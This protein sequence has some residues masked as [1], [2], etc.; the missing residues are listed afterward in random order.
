MFMFL[1]SKLGKTCLLLTCICSQLPMYAHVSFETIGTM[2]LK[3]FS[4]TG[5]SHENMKK[6]KS[7]TSPL[8]ISMSEEDKRRL[9]YQIFANYENH[10][11]PQAVQDDPSQ[12]TLLEDLEI[13]YSKGQNAQATIF[14][15]TVAPHVHTFF[16][17][18][19]A[20]KM[21]A[22]PSSNRDDLQAKQDLIK[23]LTSNDVLLQELEEL[24]VALKDAETNL[25]SFWVKEP[26]MTR[27]L[28]NKLLFSGD[29]NKNNQSSTK[30]ELLTRWGNVKTALSLSVD[31]IGFT[32]FNYAMAKVMHKQEPTAPVPSLKAA[33]LGALDIYNPVSAVK[34][35][36]KLATDHDMYT[37]QKNSVTA[38]LRQQLRRDPT[39]LEISSSLK[40]WRRLS[41]AGF[42][43]GAALKAGII[44]YKISTV[45]SALTFA[46]QKRDI[47]NFI[48][49]R[50]ISVSTYVRALQQ[51]HELGK[52]YPSIVNG[53]LL[54][55]NGVTQAKLKTCS[56]ECAELIKLLLTP[57]FKGSPSFFS[58]TGRV[59]AAYTLMN[60]E[61]DCLVPGLMTLGQLDACVAIAKLYKKS[62]NNR[63]VYSYA[64][65]EQSEQPHIRVVD[66]WNP[67][68]D[69]SVVVT[70][71]MEL[72]LPCLARNMILTG[73]NTG[74]KSTLL[75]AMLLNAWCAQTL[76]IV[77]AASYCA[78][79]F[80][81]LASY[82]NI[83]DDTGS[84][85][86]NYKAQVKRANAIV[87]SCNKLGKREF[88]F[89]VMD[90]L[91]TGTGPEKAAEGA[92]KI[93][94]LMTSIENV[95]FILAT[96]YINEV[97]KIETETEGLCKNFRI[98]AS[99]DISGNIIRKF[100]LEEG[101]SECNIADTILNTA[102]EG[103]QN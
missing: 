54:D 51:V 22:D 10:V 25:L 11:D 45:K 23:Q 19:M 50:L 89:A 42:G 88:A 64:S 81:Y 60:N 37:E 26:K 28:I 52:R 31:I 72:G 13:F 1:N 4:L 61:K 80:A 27:E 99:K 34:L 41:Y 18:A 86:S 103:I 76:T 70:N 33:F 67:L 15:R 48:Q 73:S 85:D 82:M 2:R 12:K 75:K 74:G 101:I 66:F 38:K 90:E 63:V 43:L 98:D 58:R 65:Y 93:A 56:E 35:G 39:E 102:I 55:T 3:S 59:L 78:T 77:P 40:M 5:S 8:C 97:P 62:I 32:A 44:A 16:G 83:A 100:K 91:F 87:Q 71:S 29:H 36:W 9:V 17:E 21:F 96:H 7:E 92:Y 79:P 47:A 6:R 20:A 95:C 53:L 69:S 94:H 68:V 84:G 46:T 30:L 49:A 57:T 14:E 24:L